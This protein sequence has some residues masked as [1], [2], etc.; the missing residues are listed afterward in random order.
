MHIL[1]GVE[2]A[3]LAKK[4]LLFYRGFKEAHC[5]TMFY[6][7]T[8]G[9]KIQSVTKN[10]TT[11]HEVKEQLVIGPQEVVN[12]EVL[13]HFN[14]SDEQ[15]LPRYGG[16][17]VASAGLL[18][19]GIFH[20]STVVDP[21]FNRKTYL[22]LANL[23]SYPGPRMIPCRDK[24]AKIMIFEYDPHELLPLGWEV[25][26]S[27]QGVGQDEL[28]IFYA[29]D[30]APWQPA[31]QASP[32][33][34]KKI[35]DLGIP[36]D[37]L[38]VALLDHDQKLNTLYS[39]TVFLETTFKELTEAV[40]EQKNQ[41]FKV[42]SKLDHITARMDYL[43]NDINATREDLQT[44]RQTYIEEVNRKQDRKIERLRFQWNTWLNFIVA[45]VAAIIGILGTVLV[46]Q[47][48]R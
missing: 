41:L 10:E 43:N 7:L 9:Y 15:G 19:V 11:F 26:P 44:W 32:Q 30:A 45:I 28:P 37:Q 24:I 36:Y 18:S 12:V 22:T 35:I 46:A 42:E 6:S 38:A 34:L 3:G 14:F 31:Q 25:T 47:W 29:P 48:L 23:R 16:L 2:I 40:G 33:E 39:H 27:Y 4:G 8:L 21:G 17:I 13:E 20:P 5:E 1:T